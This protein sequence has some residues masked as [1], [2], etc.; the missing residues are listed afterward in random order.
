MLKK[1]LTVIRVARVLYRNP[2]PKLDSG[3]QKIHSE[4][5]LRVFSRIIPHRL[6]Y[7]LLHRLRPQC[8]LHENWQ[9][10]TTKQEYLDQ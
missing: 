4:T 9:K 6:N 5:S 2:W 3:S 7:L 8:K 10:K 1:Y